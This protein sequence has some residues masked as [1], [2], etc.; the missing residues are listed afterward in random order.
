[1]LPDDAYEISLLQRRI[2]FLESIDPVRNQG[3]IC[4]HKGY[5]EWVRRKFAEVNSRSKVLRLLEELE[6]KGTQSDR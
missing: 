2:Q 5:L 3:R 6:A 4:F 1:M